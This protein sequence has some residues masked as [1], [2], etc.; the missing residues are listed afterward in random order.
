MVVVIAN[1][2]FSW[3]TDQQSD[4][5]ILPFLQKG[6]TLEMFMITTNEFKLYLC[7]SLA[8]QLEFAGQWV[9]GF[10]SQRREW[11]SSC[12]SLMWASFDQEL[13]SPHVWICV[14]P[15]LRGSCQLPPL[16]SPPPCVL[17][18]DLRKCPPWVLVFRCGQG[19]PVR[20]IWS[21]W[22]RMCKI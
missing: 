7:W 16:Q 4:P 11:A 19:I 10:S 20:V 17:C 8:C 1:Y 2:K 6:T 14:S 22:K 18:C 9:Q 21:L 5:Y 12:Q 15:V 3:R 13:S